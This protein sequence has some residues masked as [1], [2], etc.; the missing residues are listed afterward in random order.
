[1]AVLPVDLKATAVGQVDA[2]RPRSDCLRREL[3][4]TLGDFRVDCR[5][6]AVP[7]FDAFMAHFSIFASLFP[8]TVLI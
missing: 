5:T 4:L 6:F 7:E 8:V 3:Y 1:M 2:N